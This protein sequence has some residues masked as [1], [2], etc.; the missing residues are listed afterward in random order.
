MHPTEKKGIL[1]IWK[2]IEIGIGIIHVVITLQ[3]FAKK[4]EKISWKEVGAY[5]KEIITKG[6]NPLP[7]FI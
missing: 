6:V 5:C 3:L 1:N 4:Q 7:M 2:G